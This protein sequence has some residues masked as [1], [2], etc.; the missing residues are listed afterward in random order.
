MYM[1]FRLQSVLA[2]MEFQTV[3]WISSYNV[4][5]WYEGLWAV[6]SK[7]LEFRACFHYSVEVLNVGSTL[8]VSSVISIKIFVC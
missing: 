8:Q 7:G 2:L 3:P 6:D 4:E 5:S 1:N